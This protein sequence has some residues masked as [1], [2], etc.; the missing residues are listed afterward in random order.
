M[1]FS[2]VDF[3][4]FL[5]YCCLV[6][7]LGLYVSRRK[8]GTEETSSD[9]FLAGR[10][11]PWWAVGA[12]LIASNI[13]AEQFIGMSGSGYAIGLGIAG[14]EWIGALGLLVVAKFFLPIFM[15]TRIYTMP[16]F[17]EIRFDH[18]VRTSLAIF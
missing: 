3:V 1:N 8:K 18:R 14:Y 7:S 6:V 5:G 15:K 12:S 9:Y 10:S 2:T 13:S 17:L 11:L 16:Q 4:I